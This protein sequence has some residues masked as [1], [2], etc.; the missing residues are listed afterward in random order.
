MDN[1]TLESRLAALRDASAAR[2]PQLTHLNERLFADLRKSLLPKA[3]EIGDHAPDIDLWVAQDGTRSRLSWVLDTGP[4]VLCF[5]RG[6]WDPYSNVQATA[7][8]RAYP[9]ISAFGARLLFIGP[10][11]RHNARKMADKWSLDYPVIADAGGHNMDAFRISYEIPDYM[12]ADYVNLGFPELNPVTAWRLPVTAT[13]IV[14]QMSVI[15]L[16]HL[17]ADYTRRL[18]PTEI[19]AALRKL[20]RSIAA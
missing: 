20:K 5:Y 14:D 13:Y 15:R 16:R 6:H 7:L 3:L 10:E 9:D 8:Q 18:E 12:R 19:A 17:D 1:V 4:A 11:M 2:L